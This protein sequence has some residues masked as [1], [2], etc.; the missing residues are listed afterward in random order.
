ML[1]AI[2]TNLVQCNLCGQNILADRFLRNNG[3]LVKDEILSTLGVNFYPKKNILS[4]LK[5]SKIAQTL[6]K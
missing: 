5:I 3:Y 2:K 6:L 4:N 1:F